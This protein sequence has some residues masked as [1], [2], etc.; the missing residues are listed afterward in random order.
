M[1]LISK[2]FWPNK[3]NTVYCLSSL[4]CSISTTFKVKHQKRKCFDLLKI[5]KHN[6]QK[7]RWGFAPDTV[8]DITVLSHTVLWSSV[9]YCSSISSFEGLILM[10]IK[11]SSILQQSA[12]K[13]FE[14][15]DREFKN[16]AGALPQNPSK[17]E[18]FS[19]F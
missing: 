15:S 6:S 17:I 9:V 11:K 3:K 10:S 4:K 19:V 1:C 2:Y 16:F 7:F 18:Q 13:C 8:L 12:L 5:F 14:F